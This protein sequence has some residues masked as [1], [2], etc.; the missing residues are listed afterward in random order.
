ME[1]GTIGTANFL[2]LI[3]FASTFTLPLLGR[4]RVE[5]FLAVHGI[6]LIFFGEHVVSNIVGEVYSSLHGPVRIEDDLSTRFY[7]HF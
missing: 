5:V 4:R 2:Y 7:T 3:V 6:D 1:R